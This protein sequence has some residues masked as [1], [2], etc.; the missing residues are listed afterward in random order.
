MDFIKGEVLLFN[1]PYGWTSFQL[2]N[3]I[4][5]TIKHERKIKNIKVGHAGTLDPL[6]TGLVIIC[7][8]KETKSIERYQSLTKEYI[9]TFRLG[10]TTPSFDLETEIDGNFP[11]EHVNEEMLKDVLK[12]YTGEIIQEPPAFS[13]KFVDGVRAY[14][15]ARKGKDIKLSGNKIT[16]YTLEVLTFNL[17][18]I[19]LRIECSK[20]TYIRALARDIGRSLQSGAYLT[21]LIRQRIGNFRVENAFNIEEFERNLVFL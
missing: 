11:F 9:A 21:D 16:I 10:A 2:V 1:K 17:P 20:G 14:K 3:K 18:Y 4:R 5:F 8:G 12:L 13:A 15:Y 19:T 6:A 7:T